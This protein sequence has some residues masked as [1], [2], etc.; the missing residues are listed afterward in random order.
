LLIVGGSNAATRFHFAC[1]Q[2]GDC[3]ATHRHGPQGGAKRPLVAYLVAGSSTAAARY[4]SGFPQG[5]Q[6]LG[7]VEGRNIDSVWRYAE[8]DLTRIPALADELVRIKPD[9]IVTG[10]SAAILAFKRATATIPI[11][12]FALTDP[13]GF[14]FI[15]S[16]A[17][18]GGQVT[19]ILITLDSLPAKLLQLALEVLPSATRIGL[20]SNVS[21]PTHAVYRRNAE[22]AADLFARNLVPVEVRVPDKLDATFQTWMHER[23]DLGLV[24]YDAMFL[25]ERRPIAALATAARLPIMYGF[26]EHVEDGG[27]MSYGIDLRESFRR[28]AI[29][30]DKIL[31][32]AKP[33]DLPVELPTKLELI[34]NLNT[35]KELGLTIPQSILFRA[36]EVIE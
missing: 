24:I 8:G 18:P 36:D 3:L 9:V 32:G 19:G 26:R 29:F 20:L 2:C 25:S 34:I 5:L 30:V 22:A 31:K 1:R 21:N 28:A 33:G 11:V 15:A 4:A 23:V 10:T 16:M 27:L 14:G 17:R 13:E 12:S 6:E 35:A 7:Y